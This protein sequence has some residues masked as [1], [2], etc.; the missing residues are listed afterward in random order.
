MTGSRPE[1][2]PVY[3]GHRWA[4]GGA[5]VTHRAHVFRHSPAGLS[6]GCAG[7]VVSADVAQ[8]LGRAVT[9]VLS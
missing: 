1:V 3:R 9:G 6:W 4:T 2:A 7:S 8:W 5:V